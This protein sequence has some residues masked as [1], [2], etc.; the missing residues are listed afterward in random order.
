M[1]FL[2]EFF[3]L[4]FVQLDLERKETERFKAFTYE[5]LINRDKVNLD[6][7]WLKDNS[8]DDIENLPHPDEL[9]SDILE[10]LEAVYEEFRRFSN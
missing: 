10:E 6:I 4:C 3:Q 9:L 2:N 1:L 5:E 7:T 8:L